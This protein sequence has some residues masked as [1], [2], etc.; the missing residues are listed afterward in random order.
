M[1]QQ[2]SSRPYKKARDKTMLEKMFDKYL[3]TKA[4]FE[5]TLMTYDVGDETEGTNAG[6][7]DEKLEKK[8]LS[9]F[10]I[11]LQLIVFYLPLMNLMF[12]GTSLPAVIG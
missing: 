11:L 4:P 10:G 3:A 5:G 6:S 12:R 7:Q 8:F 2:D 1:E 9:F